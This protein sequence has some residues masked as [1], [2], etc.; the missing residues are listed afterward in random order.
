MLKKLLGKKD[1]KTESA[2]SKKIATMDLTSMKLYVKGSIKD[3]VVDAEGL[4]LILKRLSY[5]LN[6]KG[7]LYLRKEDMDTKKKKAFDLVLLILSSK[8]IN[9]QTLELAQKFCDVYAEI[10]KEYDKKYKEI[11]E[12]RFKDA[13]K[14]AMAN[15]DTLVSIQKKMDLLQ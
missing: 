13:L 12:Q 8:K 15:I 1:V 2:L 5:P 11:Y 9:V 6:E 4:N 14:V 3:L 7:V 10:I